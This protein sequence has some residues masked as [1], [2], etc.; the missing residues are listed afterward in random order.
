MSVCHEGLVSFFCMCVCHVIQLSVIHIK[1]HRAEME[2]RDSL[3]CTQEHAT[4]TLLNQMNPDH[5]L[6][7]YFHK[8]NSNNGRCGPDSSGSG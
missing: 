6:P 3:P 4:G 2:P 7:P 8:I 5:N 1:L